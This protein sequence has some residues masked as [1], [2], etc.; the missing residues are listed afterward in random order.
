M[1]DFRKFQGGKINGLEGVL[2]VA[3][4]VK[5]LALLQLWCWSQLRLGFSPWFRNFHML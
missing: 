3:Q 2:T 4:W 1:E 5:D